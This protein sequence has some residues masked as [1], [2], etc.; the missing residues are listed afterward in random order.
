VGDSCPLAADVLEVRPQ[1]I[2]DEAGLPVPPE[3]RGVTSVL[4]IRR[5]DPGSMD[6][7]RAYRSPAPEWTG[8]SREMPGSAT[9]LSAKN[10]K[11]LIPDLWNQA[12]TCTYP[13]GPR[14]T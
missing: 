12:L 1:H 14:R 10:R 5:S 2:A 7:H 3:A 8:L 9:G 11:G 13:C 4:Q 6:A